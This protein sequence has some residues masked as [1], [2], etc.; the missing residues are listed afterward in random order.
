MGIFRF[1]RLFRR[2]RKFGFPLYEAYLAA[3]VHMR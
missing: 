3:R 2:A 1:W